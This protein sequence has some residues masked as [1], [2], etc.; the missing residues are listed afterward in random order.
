V[1][2]SAANQTGGWLE[3]WPIEGGPSGGSPRIVL[4]ASGSTFWQAKFSPNGRWL[5]FVAIGPGKWEVGVANADG[6]TNRK[7]ISVAMPQAVVDKPRWAVDGKRLYFLVSEGAYLNLWSVGFDPERGV[8]SG[9][10]SP[11]GRYNLPSSRIGPG[12]STEFDV[13]RRGAFLEMESASGN[14]WMLDNV[15]R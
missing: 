8:L 3:L 12:L 1:L 2:V 7:W 9:S 11:V 5:A 10:P 6:P 13:S 14:I 15:D 4:K